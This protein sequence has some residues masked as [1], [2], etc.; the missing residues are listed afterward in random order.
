MIK[1]IGFNNI[2]ALFPF[3]KAPPDAEQRSTSG[4]GDWGGGGG[5]WGTAAE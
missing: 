2:S 3:C 1:A 4:G 5:G